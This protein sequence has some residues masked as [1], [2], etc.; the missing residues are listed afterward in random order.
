MTG[1]MPNT[2]RFVC[3]CGKV[4]KAP[5]RLAGKG[6]RCPACGTDVVVPE[7]ARNHR[8]VFASL[9]DDS[10]PTDGE[11]SP[12]QPAAD[13]RQDHGARLNDTAML[14]MSPTLTDIDV[15]ADDPN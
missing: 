10:P 14:S 8:I 2:I 12:G 9:P 6:S 4:L 1:E 7:R 5:A 3:R 13:D 11:W 15:P